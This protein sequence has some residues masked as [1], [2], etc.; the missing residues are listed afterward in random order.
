MKTLGEHG[1]ATAERPVQRACDARADRHHAATERIRVGRFD[2]K[3][4]V[5]RLE[6][7]MNQAKVDAVTNRREAPFERADERH[8]SQ[9][10]KAGTELDGHVC[11]EPSRDAS[12]AAVRNVRLSSPPSSCAGSTAAPATAFL[13]TKSELRATAKHR[14]LEYGDVLAGSITV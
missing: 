7:V 9:G 2:E 10:W 13:Q 6:A 4:S 5:R 12:A 8:G 11:G 14:Q 1:A 3:V